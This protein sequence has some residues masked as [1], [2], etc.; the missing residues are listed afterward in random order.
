M[1][2]SPVSTAASEWHKWNHRVTQHSAR[3]ALTSWHWGQP[4]GPKTPKP[5]HPKKQRPVLWCHCSAASYSPSQN[6]TSRPPFSEVPLGPEKVILA[7]IALF[8][9][10]CVILYQKLVC[11]YVIAKE[12]AAALLKTPPLHSPTTEAALRAVREEQWRRPRCSGACWDFPVC[13]VFHCK[14]CCHSS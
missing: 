14:H 5:G 4:A 12:M 8:Y 6:R 10:L 11:S 7:I 13:Q 1:S 3:W 9:A 2:P